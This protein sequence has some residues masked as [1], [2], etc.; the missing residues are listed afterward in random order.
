MPLAPGT[1]VLH[2]RIVRSI[3]SGGMG[4]V[5]EADDT[6][7][8]R[9]VALKFLPAEVARDRPALERF[10]REARAASALN[11]PSICTVHAIEE[12]DGT[13]FIAMELLEGESLDRRIADRPL[14]WDALVGTATQIAEALDAAHRRGIIHRDI[15][16]ANI[17]VTTDG[18]AK[19]L[20]FGIAKIGGSAAEQ[21]ET[22]AMNTV[23][24]PLT[25]EGVTVGT[26]AYMSPEQARGEELDARS[27]LFSLGA[28]LYEMST[29]RR[30]FEGNTSGVVFQKILDASAP[31]EP[32]SLNPTLPP[33]L[34]QIILKALEK[35][36]D[37]RY[38]SA[39][40]LRADLKRLKRDATSGRLAFVPVAATVA[41]AAPISS[42]A[43]LLAEARRHKSVTGVAALVL[44]GVTAA[45]AYGLYA[46]T[47]PATVTAPVIDR[48]QKMTVTR[49]TTSGD[50]SGCGSISPDGRYVVY[51][52]FSGHLRV[53]QVATGSTIDLGG[54]TGATAF[55]PDGDFIYITDATAENF[56][57]ELSV[58]PAIGGDARRVLTNIAG[59][60]GLSPDGK[61]LAFTRGDPATRELSLMTADVDGANQKRL[62][63]GHMDSTWFATSGVSWSADGKRL[64][65]IQGTVV[66]GYR[67]RPVLVDVETGKVEPLGST[68]WVDLGRPV[69]LPDGSGVLFPARERS[70]GAFQFWIARY[71]GGE[72]ARIT[73]DARGFGDLSVGVTADGSTIATVPWDIVSNLFSTTPDAGAPL[74]QWTSGVRIDGASGMAPSADGR[75]VFSSADGIDVGIFSIDAPGAR[76]RRLT[77]DYA[78][79]P[80]SP[81]DGRFV[82]YQAIHEGRFRIWRVQRDGSDARVLSRGEDD[83]APTVSPDGKWIYYEAAEPKPGLMRL[84]SDGGDAVRVSERAV[85]VSDISADGRELLVVF[86]DAFGARSAVMDAETGAIKTELDLPGGR[87]RWSHLPGVVTYIVREDGVDNIWERPVAGGT[88]KP[89][90]K[91]TAGRIYNVEYAP[92]GKR[93]FV[94]KGQRTGD[95]VLIRNFR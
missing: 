36:R 32:R 6:R 52:D 78:E 9:R 57:G 17:F 55:S 89:L 39:A 74:E 13:P 67:L 24:Q 68:T 46:L 14:A 5:Y 73:N 81:S 47:R 43:V 75:L 4:V 49:L 51:C 42:G 41:A 59:A 77:R 61:R 3:G 85:S 95:V 25:G 66:G 2:Y 22:V 54:T 79:V 20:D 33:A 1:S 90:T 37:L 50:V 38:Q 53:R 29:G 28:V 44:L 80:S 94:A 16:P 34:E 84:P 11:H 27:D 48:A 40:D 76:P 7:L 82:A 92:G 23:R 93:L 70:E 71:P 10:Q 65:V 83:I 8:G 18:R 69:W 45:A 64:A 86:K 63:V 58:V 88:A 35:D 31:P 12:A 21:V 30:A 56:K 26:V 91:F 15:K 62:A 19:V 72:P 87:P 60:V